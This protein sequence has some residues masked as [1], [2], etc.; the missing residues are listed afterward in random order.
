MRAFSSCRLYLA[1]SAKSGIGNGTEAM[2]ASAACAAASSPLPIAASAATH[3][4]GPIAHD[5]AL[6]AHEVHLRSGGLE[7]LAVEPEP[8]LAGHHRRAAGG[9]PLPERER[10]VELEEEG[11]RV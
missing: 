3:G 1:K 7:H 5:V 9:D 10:V 6:A 2:S 8:D 11:V 4:S